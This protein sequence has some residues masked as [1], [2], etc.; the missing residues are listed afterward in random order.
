MCNKKDRYLKN[1]FTYN[2]IFSKIISAKNILDVL[3]PKIQN[4]RGMDK[5]RI[6]LETRSKHTLHVSTDSN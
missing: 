2:I 4:F 6:P 1:N 5:L 3:L